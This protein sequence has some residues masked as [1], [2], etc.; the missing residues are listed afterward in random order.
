MTDPNLIEIPYGDHSVISLHSAGLNIAGIMTP[1]DVS[2]ALSVETALRAALD[3]PIGS[4]TLQCLGEPGDEYLIVAD[5]MTRETP[6]AAMTAVVA[7]SLSAAGVSDCQIK[8][9]I[10]TGTHRPMTDAEI[11]ERFGEELTQRFEICNHDYQTSTLTDLGLTDNGTPISVNQRVLDADVVIGM[12]SIVPH[13]IPGYSGGSKIIQPGVSGEPT[14][15]STHMFSAV[16]DTQILGMVESPVRR[17]MEEVAARAGLTAILNTTLNARGEMVD[18]FFGDPKAAFRAGTKAS[19]RI[20]GLD[21][22]SNVDI[23]IAGSHPCDIE[24]W[25]AHKSL[26]PAAQMVRPGGT[27]IVVAP[28]PEGVAMTHDDVL[29]YADQ[30]YSR[31]RDLVDAG[32]VHDPVGASNAVAWSRIREFADISL[33]SGGISAEDCRALGFRPFESLDDALGDARR[34]LGKDASVAVMTHAPDTL[35]IPVN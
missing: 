15:A 22:P 14:T 19:R 21:A 5:D 18:A 33:V 28:C 34:R 17:E 3:R 10:A 2:G 32:A 12:S 25:Q 35:P 31:I 29:N 13:H 9:L 1:V 23:V 8:V 4:P 16:S 20:Y 27:I 24:F 6:V 30:T 26:F 11:L 7:E